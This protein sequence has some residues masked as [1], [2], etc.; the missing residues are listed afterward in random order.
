MELKPLLRRAAV[1]EWL[2]SL[3]MCPWDVRTLI[4]DGTIKA[5]KIRNTRRAYYSKAQ[6]EECVLGK[7]A[8]K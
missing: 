1:V 2:Q 8:V 3:G 5:I 4:E 7:L 6:I